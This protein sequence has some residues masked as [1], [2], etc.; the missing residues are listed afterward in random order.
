MSSTG[1]KAPDHTMS[2]AVRQAY[3]AGED[4]E[5]MEPIVRIGADGAPEGMIRSG[6][7]VVFYDIRGE[8]EIEL[9]SAFTQRDFSSF[10][11]DPAMRTQWVTMIQYS[12]DLDAKVAFPPPGAV[13]DTLCGLVSSAGLKQ[14]KVVESEKAVHLSFFLNGKRNEP[15]EG[16]ERVVVHSPK[17]VYAEPSMRAEEVGDALIE[18][19]Q[20]GQYHLI[21]GNFANVDVVG[22]SE[23]RE[24]I[25]EAVETVDRQLG[26]VTEAAL[27][28]GFSL[29][30]TADH[31]TVESWLYPEGTI[32]TGHTTSPVPFLV[33]EPDADDGG[34]SL[35]SGGS[36]VDVAPTVLEL[37]GLEKP[38]AMTGESLIQGRGAG[39]GP[40]K[41]VLLVLDGWGLAEPGPG[42][43]ISQARTPSMDDLAGRFPRTELLASQMAVGLPEGTVGNSEAGHLHIGAGRKVFSDRVRINQSLEDGSFYENEAFL[44]AM[45]GAIRDGTRL[46]LLGI[47]SFYSSH[48]SIDHLLAL[49]RMARQR[50]VPEVCIHALMG[51]RGERPE[52]G[53]AYLELVENEAAELGLGRICTVIG[54]FWALDREDN[55]D[56]VE[57]T[58]RLLVEG[59]GRPA[60]A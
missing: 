42:N 1:K 36:L 54:R 22:H 39:R 38:A 5:S 12:P 27:A 47:I 28:A 51:R 41:V 3:R 23:S 7:H 57:K 8:R 59:A 24:A 16:E 32:D 31:G 40:R 60:G 30:V 44:H 37:M 46:H 29:A 13:E 45:E 10:P 56:R 34:L 19:I 17:D 9:T 2:E 18:A 43:L 58:Y 49:L 48:G 50:G 55:W 25:L 53:G 11:V 33:I 4:E 52:S 14:V 26:R 21:T 35:R 6:D 20:G 15:F